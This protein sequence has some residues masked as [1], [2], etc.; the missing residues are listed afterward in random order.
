MI[1]QSNCWYHMEIQ[2]QICMQS[3]SRIKLVIKNIWNSIKVLIKSRN[4]WSGNISMIQMVNSTSRATRYHFY[5]DRWFC[6]VWTQYDVAYHQRCGA[7]EL[8]N[9][10]GYVY[11]LNEGK[12]YMSVWQSRILCIRHQCLSIYLLN[13]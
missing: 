1:F 4:K 13:K 10:F 8:C 12:C 11:I 6:L 9:C 3:S 2:L 7:G 5:F